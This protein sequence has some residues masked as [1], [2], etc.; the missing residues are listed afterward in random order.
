MVHMILS[1]KQKH[2]TDMESRLVLARG[3]GRGNGI[4]QVFEVGEYKL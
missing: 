1:T 3:R 2:I 4:D